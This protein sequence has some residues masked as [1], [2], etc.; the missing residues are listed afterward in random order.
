MKLLG[1]DCKTSHDNLDR[2]EKEGLE[3]LQKRVKAG[4]LVI[5]QTDKS[6]KFCVLTKS[7]T[8]KLQQSTSRMTGS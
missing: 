7:S 6:G 1:E 2:E 8:W 5:A 4:E 3:S